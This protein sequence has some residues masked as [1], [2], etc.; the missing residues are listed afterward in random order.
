MSATVAALKDNLSPPVPNA[1]NKVTVVGS[2]CVG[3]AS[4][5]AMMAQVTCCVN[6]V[7]HYLMLMVKF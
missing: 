3:M 1:R 4:A 2:G 6:Q 5:F 7:N